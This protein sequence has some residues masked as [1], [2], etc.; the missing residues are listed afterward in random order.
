M[1]LYIPLTA[2]L[3]DHAEKAYG[4][5]KCTAVVCGIA[6]FIIGQG[7]TNFQN[8]SARDLNSIRKGYIQYL[9][10]NELEYGFAT[11]WNAAV[12]TELSNGRIE[13][14]GLDPR[15][16]TGADGR[17]FGFSSYGN[18]KKFFDPHYHPGES[19]LILARNEWDLFRSRR[20][21]LTPDY[22]DSNFVIITY[23]SA[24]IIHHDLGM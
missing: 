1:V 3:F 18:H 10:D 24:E 5:L 13:A 6:L 4:Y 16:R 12:T 9:L 2:M 23:P 7:Y 20:P 21:S 15:V 11:F 8:L 17:L 22:E 14:A 19:F